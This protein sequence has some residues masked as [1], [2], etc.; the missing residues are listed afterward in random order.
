MRENQEENQVAKFSRLL[1]G[2]KAS[3][4]KHKPPKRLAGLVRL[5]RLVEKYPEVKKE[6]LERTADQKGTD[7]SVESLLVNFVGSDVSAPGL[8]RM[9]KALKAAQQKSLKPS[10]AAQLVKKGGGIEGFGD[11]GGEPKRRV[12]RPKVRNAVV[13]PLI[14][15][16]LRRTAAET[17]DIRTESKRRWVAKFGLQL[18]DGQYLL[19]D[20]VHLPRKEALKLLK[21]YS[22][23]CQEL[24]ARKNK[25]G[26][27]KNSG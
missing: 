14:K 22:P 7:R 19:F 21:K 17:M 8:S 18:K 6:L 11:A 1:E 27:R 12:H 5:A 24:L 23:R 9:R 4:A 20:D 15:N 16:E 25:Y 26:K 3:Y 10:E 2:L 13:E